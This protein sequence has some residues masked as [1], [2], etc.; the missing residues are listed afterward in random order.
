MRGAE[1]S[2]GV[3]QFPKYHYSLYSIGGALNGA[4]LDTPKRAGTDM[5]SGAK[6]RGM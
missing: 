6:E 4:I 3:V 1:L 5:A 2:L